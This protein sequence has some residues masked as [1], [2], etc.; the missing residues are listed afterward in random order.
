MLRWDY[1]KFEGFWRLKAAGPEAQRLEVWL[2]SYL[3]VTAESTLSRLIKEY[4]LL[5]VQGVQHPGGVRGETPAYPFLRLTSPFS[6]H[7]L[8]RV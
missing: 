7:I 4:P 5:R 2:P 3:Q 6:A 8:L 1:R